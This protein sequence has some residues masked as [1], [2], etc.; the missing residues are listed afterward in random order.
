MNNISQDVLLEKYAKNGE[1]SEKEVYRRVAVAASKGDRRL[2]ADFYDAMVAGL[3]PAGRIMSQL[4]TGTAATAINCFVQP[5]GDCISGHDD[6][7]RPGI[8]TALQQAAETMRRGGG[9][10]YNF[11]HIRPAGSPVKGTQSLA[12]G[13]VS[14]MRVFDASCSTV[15]SAGS[16][17]GA[18]MAVL[19]V[20]HPD[21]EEFIVCKQKGGLTNFNLSVGV[22]DAF[23]YSV[24]NGDDWDLTFGGKI[25]KTLPARQLWDLITRSTYDIG[26]PGILFPD[27]WNEYNNLYYAEH[28]EACNPCCVTGDTLVLTDQGHIPI[29]ELIGRS[30][31]VWNGEEFS[32]VVPFNSGVRSI[33]RVT[34][35][36]GAHID[37]TDNHK[38]ILYDGTRVETK[39]LAIGALLTKAHM[40]IIENGDDYERDAYSQG[41]FSGDGSEGCKKSNVYSPKYSVIPRLCG[42]VNMTPSPSAPDRLNWYHGDMLPKDLVPVNGS[43]KYKLEW[44]A[45]L[46]D[47]DGCVTRDKNGNGLQIVSVNKKFLDSVRIMLTAMGVNAKVV[48][49]ASD[50]DKDFEKGGAYYC[51]SSYRLLI[52]NTDTFHLLSL[53]LTCS[54]IS[55]EHKQPQRDARR[56]VKVVSIE[57][58]GDE[59]ETYC[60]TEPKRHAGVFNGVLTG[61]S[62]QPLPDYGCCCL[63]SINLTKLIREPF[64]A[65]ARFDWEAFGQI[66][67]LGVKLL[68]NVLDVTP[69]PLEEQRLEAMEKRRI[70]LGFMGLGDA[71]LMLGMNYSDNKGRNFAKNVAKMLRD[72]AYWASVELSK[73]LGPF[74]LFDRDQY[75][76]GVFADRLGEDLRA[77]I[78]SYGIRNSHLTSIA[79]T[80]TISLA[81]GDNCSNGIEPPF[82]WTYERKKRMADGSTQI[83]KVTDHSF[84]ISGFDI[85]NLPSN[86]QT[87]L[88]IGVDDHVRMLEIVQ[89]YVDSSISKT[90]NIPEDYPFEDFQNIYMRA[91]EGGLKG[92]ATYRP[93]AT[94][95]A[96]LSVSATPVEPRIGK[97]PETP[98]G[99]P[100]W[101]YCVD[102]PDGKIAAHIGEL[103]GKPFEVWI[104]GEGAG[105][106]GALAKL[107]SS[108][109]RVPDRSWIIGKL[110]NLHDFREPNGDFW[111]P[112]PGTGKRRNY[113]SKAAWLASVILHRYGQKVQKAGKGCPVCGDV[114]Q[115]RDG[116][117]VCDS[118]GYQGSCS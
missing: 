56:F 91:F 20:D 37:C 31:Y 117:E 9:V 78:F 73:E 18:Q 93:N 108:D 106:L 103:D 66:V 48:K 57:K 97:R 96:V 10:G 107:L 41:F 53:G 46:L 64:T 104:D 1:T 14:Y 100:A 28:I 113:P 83:Y 82:S 89:P 29:I 75:L 11:S 54:R 116:C 21:I 92:L 13:P 81:F 38:F 80:G 101:T 3:V 59:Q 5:V 45:G 72:H 109:M 61:Q 36:N 24:K 86:W 47:S 58:L 79:P 42:T 114:L 94:L 4:G 69:W 99:N 22:S 27:R 63:A 17:R 30:V 98:N 102:T 43:I 35:S 50:G 19:N 67:R 68:D 25:Y 7:G 26:E 84:K 39:D 34:L 6:A 62:E 77:D 40:P 23:I 74:P 55:V 65:A 2:E 71:I 87:A 85:N 32:T 95:G 15:E 112:V 49:G 115:K 16:R 12:S 44:L 52:G 33:Y 51:Q 70:G 90:V 105:Q 118:C 110:E 88:E 60:F 111:A 76:K 8:Y